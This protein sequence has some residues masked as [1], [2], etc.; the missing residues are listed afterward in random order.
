MI[1][2]SVPKGHG[3]D[4]R[5]VRRYP[6][7]ALFGHPIGYSFVDQGDSEFEQSHND[8]LVGNES[9]FSSILDE[10]RGSKQEGNDIV[11][12]IDPQPSGSPSTAS[13]G[14][15]RRGGRDR[16]EHRPGQGAGLAT[17]PTTRTGSPTNCDK[18]NR[19]E[20]EAPLLNR[21]TQASYPPGSTF[22]VVTAAAALDSGT[23]TPTRR[24][25]RPARSTSQGQPLENDFGT[26]Y[27]GPIASTT[28]LTNSVNT[29]FAQVG[30]KVGEDTLFEYMDRFGFNAKPPIDLPS[31]QLAASGIYRTGSGD[32][33]APA[34][35][36]TSPGSRS[37]R[38]GCWSTPL[39]MAEV[40]AAVANRRQADEAAD[41]GPGDRPRRPGDRSASTPPSSASRSARRRRRS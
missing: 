26:E 20:A 21:A 7:G 17:R 18:L 3:D 1:A 9:E 24:S 36:S 39:Q 37:A 2:R 41:L 19:N 28:A 35:R 16:A 30:E 29:W 15:L 11:T 13:S 38:S 32:C 34:T 12:N 40:A 8:E 4:L 6:E 22:K 25:T 10:L 33:S 27:F 14:R 23:I 5:Y 31:D